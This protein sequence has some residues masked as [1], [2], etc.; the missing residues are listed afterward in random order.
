[1]QAAPAALAKTV[2]AVA[3]TKGATAGG[4]TLTLIKG[5][6]KL[7]AWTKAKTVI[8]VGAGILLAAGAATV[9]TKEIQEHRSYAWE[10]P[11]AD[12][13]VFYKSPPMVRIVPTKFLEDGGWCSDGSRGVLGIAQPLKTIVQVAYQT[14]PLHMVVVGDLPTEKYDFLAKLV[15]AQEA[16][17]KMP[18]DS[19]WA[20]ALQQEIRRKFGVA[21]RMEARETDVL[22]LEYK[23]PAAHG[24]QPADSLRQ[25]LKLPKEPPFARGRDNLRPSTS[26]SARW[27]ASCRDECKF[28]SLTG[29]G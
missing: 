19:H 22:L 11:K 2:T 20:A 8:L 1:M 23:N 16:H 4:S 7:M 29:P 3:L 13:S 28:P 12:F 17:K 24:F 21:G 26:R 27:P 10:V 14:D 5:A 18:T 6:L 15:P 9:T 25:S